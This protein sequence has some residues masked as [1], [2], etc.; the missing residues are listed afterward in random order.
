MPQAKCFTFLA[1][2][3]L[4]ANKVTGRVET[5]Y[6]PAIIVDEQQLTPFLKF[7]LTNADI[8]ESE[9]EEMLEGYF[10]E[11]FDCLTL[12]INTIGDEVN[13]NATFVLQFDVDDPV[14]LNGNEIVYVQEDGNY[15]Y[16]V[17]AA[18]SRA[19]CPRLS[20][21]VELVFDAQLSITE[22]LQQELRL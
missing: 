11:L 19:I 17:T 1:S 6:L 2:Y 14:S 16:K 3:K 20:E 21:S 7:T 5:E 15:S 18:F 4:P 13:I 12:D 8:G 22:T 9:S 10:I